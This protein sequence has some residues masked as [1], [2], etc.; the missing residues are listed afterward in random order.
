MAT[1]DIHMKYKLDID[2][3]E[4]LS[5]VNKTIAKAARY[6]HSVEFSAEDASRSDWDFFSTRQ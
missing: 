4:A 6:A 3:E 5:T 1:T 2:R